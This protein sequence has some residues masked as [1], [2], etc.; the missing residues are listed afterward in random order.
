[1]FTLA[2]SVIEHSTFKIVILLCLHIQI[3]NRTNSSKSH[4]CLSVLIFKHVQEN[5][6]FLLSETNLCYV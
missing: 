4:L 1:M 2:T 3:V 5:L 6:I